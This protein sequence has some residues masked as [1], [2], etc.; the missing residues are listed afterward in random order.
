M[1]KIILISAICTI[2]SQ[3]HSQWNL[4]GN[5]GTNAS[6]NFIGTTDNKAFKIRTNNAVRITINSSGK[7]GIGTSSPAFKLDVKGGSINTDSV[8]RIGGNTVLSVKGFNTFVGISSGVSNTTGSSNTATGYATLSSNNTGYA[9]TAN[10]MY[11]LFSNTSGSENTG[12]GRRALYNNTTGNSNTANGVEALYSNTSGN[13]H[14]ATGSYALHSNTTG[15]ENTAHGFEALYSNTTGNYNCAFGHKALRS[16]SGQYGNTAFGNNALFSCTTGSVNTAIGHNA[17]YYNTTGLSNTGIGNQALGNN[18]TGNWN[19]AIGDNASASLGTFAQASSF[20]AYAYVNASYKVR[21]GSSNIT[22]I[23]G[24]VAFS[25]PSD[26]RFKENILDDVK[27]LDFITKLKP[28]SYNFNRLK[29]AQHV[30]EPLTP[31]RKEKLIEQSQ[32]RSAGFI[33]QDVERLIRETGFTSFDAVHAPTNETDNYSVGYAE[34]VVPLVKAVQ[35][36][37]E[38]NTKLKNKI[39]SMSS[40]L[41]SLCSSNQLK[42]SSENSI[43]TDASKLEQNN[44]NPFKE[45]TTIRFYI[46]VTSGKALLKVF[47]MNGEELKSFVIS[48][49]GKGQIEITGNTLAPGIYTYVLIVD[50]LSVDTKQMVITK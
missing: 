21:I 10:G 9:N 48:A 23:E 47:S 4:T 36:L 2:C 38:E 41:E 3:A 1:K 18:T 17:L 29:Y 7:V 50:N 39:E 22:V 35:E 15:N 27:G 19:T 34:F 26:A 42:S 20:G 11:A 16:L 49:K 30:R 33:A 32:Y 8:Y 14:T 12:T 6:T 25:T 46:S 5:A 44:P 24:Q 43:A 40:C 31:G 45:N 37:N 13:Q 28:V